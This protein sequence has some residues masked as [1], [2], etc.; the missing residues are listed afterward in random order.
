M[1]NVIRLSVITVVFGLCY[2]EAA[3]Q[4]NGTT[5]EQRRQEWQRFSA[6]LQ[7][8]KKQ[9]REAFADEMARE[10][11]GDCPHATTTYDINMCL[12]DE[13]QKTTKN[14]QDY[15]YALR[16]IEAL[17]NPGEPEPV[18][19]TGKPPTAE[20]RAKEFDAVEATWKDFYDK[21]CAAAYHAYQGGTIAPSM[22][23]M[24]RL[25]LMRDRMRELEAVYDIEH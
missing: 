21:Q 25:R 12:G 22:D 20:E 15:V 7:V 18:G 17:E 23:L 1:V 19:P 14:Y 11:A 9:A 6:Q 16:G 3:A 13:V 8:F 4:G 24:S 5:R 2:F 10:K